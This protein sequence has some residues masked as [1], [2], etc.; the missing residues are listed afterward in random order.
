MLLRLPNEFATKEYDI[1]LRMQELEKQSKYEE[2]F[3]S[4]YVKPFS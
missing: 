3:Q 4:E 2:L 1:F